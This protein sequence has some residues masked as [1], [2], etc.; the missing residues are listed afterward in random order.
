LA[1]TPKEAGAYLVTVAV[2]DR[3][4]VEHTRTFR[5]VVRERRKP[6]TA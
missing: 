6:S 4:G 3:L 2:E 1:G 5:I